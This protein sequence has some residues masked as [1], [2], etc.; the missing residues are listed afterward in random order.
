M[1]AL[2]D[3]ADFLTKAQHTL[4]QARDKG[5]TQRGQKLLREGAGLVDGHEFLALPEAAQEDLLLLYAQAMRTV[6]GS[7]MP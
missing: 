6:S 7:L 1:T 2:T 5:P 4:R 3:S